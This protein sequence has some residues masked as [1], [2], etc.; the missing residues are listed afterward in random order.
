MFTPFIVK[1]CSL[2]LLRIGEK[3]I[4]TFCNIPNE[5][6]CKQ[7][8]D[9]G[10]NVGTKIGLIQKFPYLQIQVNDITMAIDLD[11]ARTI[12]VRVIDSE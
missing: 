9:A 4:V 10:I 2:E 1:G 3:A 5:P 6:I 12:Y 11:I 8:R 7:L